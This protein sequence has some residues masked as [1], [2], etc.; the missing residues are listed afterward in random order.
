M[1]H[2]RDLPWAFYADVA[3]WSY[4]E[5]RHCLM[6][7]RRL[8]AWGF[9]CGVDYPMVG[10]PY[11][12]ILEEGGGLLDVLALL[13]FFERDA[14]AHRQKAKKRFDGMAD[15]ASAQDTD[16]DWADEAIHLRYGYTWLQHMLGNDRERL[17]ALVSQAGAM[18]D[19]WLAARWERG[20]DGYVPFMERIDAKIAAAEAAGERA[21]SAEP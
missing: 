9:E 11:H 1:W 8:D 20:E 21:A 13:Y 16:Y 2:W 3:R 10:D 14:P 17:T 6:G 4:D 15:G 5:M 19:R 7:I 18:W 12:A